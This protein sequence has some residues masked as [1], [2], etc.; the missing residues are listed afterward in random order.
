MKLALLLALLATPALAD[1]DFRQRAIEANPKTS[2]MRLPPSWFDTMHAIN[3]TLLIIGE[4]QAQS[5]QALDELREMLKPKV[6]PM[7][8]AAPELPILDLRTPAE[9]DRV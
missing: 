6:V 1:D 7:L 8:R 2:A 5:R 9:G 4:Q 3:D